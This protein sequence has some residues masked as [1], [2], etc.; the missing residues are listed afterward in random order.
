VSVGLLQRLADQV[1]ARPEAPAVVEGPEVLTYRALWR[2]AGGVAAGLISQGVLPEDVVAVAEPRSA[3]WVVQVLGAWMAGAAW[4]PLEPTWPPERRAELCRRA[5][6]HAAPSGPARPRDPDPARFPGLDALAYV[7]ATSG[8]TGAPKLVEVTHRGLVPVLE[9][10]LAA[11]QLRPGDRAWWMLAPV[12]DASISDVGTALLAGATVVV[13]HADPARLP[14]AW[15]EA[16]VT[17]VDLPPALM[18]ALDPETLPDSLRVVIFGGEPSPPERVRRWARTR[19]LVQAYGPT[20]ATICTHL[21]APDPEAW[22]RPALGRPIAGMQHRLVAGELWLAGPGLARGYRGDPALTAAR[23]VEQDGLRWYRTGD[24]VREGAEGLVFGGR[25]DRQLKLAGRLIAPEEVEAALCAAPGVAHAAVW[26]EGLRLMAQVEAAPGADP[27]A[28]LS[29]T[30]SPPEPMAPRLLR[31]LRARL[32]A[33]MVP[34]ELRV[35]PLPRLPS[36]KVDFKRLSAPPAPAA[37]PVAAWQARLTQALSRPV[38]P[39]QDLF[40]AGADS[41]AILELL[42]AAEG[43]GLRLDVA[44]LHRHPTARALV[45]CFH[46]PPAAPADALPLADLWARL[47]APTWPRTTAPAGPPRRLFMT[48]ATGFLGVHVLAALAGRVEVV[49][50]VR[51]PAAAPARLAAAAARHRLEVPPPRWV[52]GDVSAPG[53]GLSPDL[54]AELAEGC[55]R[56]L[57]LA[58]Q[59]A[60]TSSLE[61]L[62]PTNVQGTLHALELAHRGRPKPLVHAGSLVVLVA[63]DGPR[64]TLREAQRPGG[65][66][67]VG[68]YAQ[69]KA[70]AEALVDGAAVPAANVR[71]GLLAGSARDRRGAPGDWLSQAIHAFAHRAAPV[72][73]DAAFDLTPVDHAAAVMAHLALAEAPPIGTFHVAAAT[74]VTAARLQ[75]ALAAAPTRVPQPRPAVARLAAPAARAASPFDLFLSTGVRFECSRTEAATGRPAPEVDDATLASY[76]AAILESP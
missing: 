11:F 33:W 62:W 13:G 64:G 7:I 39:D 34:A 63:G 59:L 36:G 72:P 69:S 58:G 68:A 3:S 42:A 35:G 18:P 51:E 28:A 43:E 45:A 4:L 22:D 10:Q 70:A 16:G 9:A 66:H 32:P 55:E 61:Q 48:G 25:V 46:Q 44:T 15:A 20:E 71:L 23:F 74:P 73:D 24:A 29:S 50:L 5:G 40:E 19:R 21:A 2:A 57:H 76:V 65:T 6:A 38:G 27:P 17:H 56:V 1:A 31:L 30:S 54:Y 60:L 12:F 52:Q 49:A 67:L 26:A 47:P 8:S 41:L 37:D 75:T 53:L 14:A